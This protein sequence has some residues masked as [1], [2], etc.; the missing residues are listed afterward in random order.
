MRMKNNILLMFFKII[1]MKPSPHRPKKLI[2]LTHPH[3]KHL[4]EEYVL[5]IDELI[6]KAKS[7]SNFDEKI[8]VISF[9]KQFKRSSK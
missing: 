3:K 2:I 8:K 7:E 1:L 5:D 4:S 6:L 9:A